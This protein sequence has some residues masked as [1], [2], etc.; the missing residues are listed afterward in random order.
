MKVH[1]LAL[2]KA[3]Q[4]R[5]VTLIKLLGTGK[6]PTLWVQL[7]REHKRLS[8]TSFMVGSDRGNKQ[9]IADVIVDKTWAN[10]TGAHQGNCGLFNPLA[11][12]VLAVLVELVSQKQGLPAGLTGSTC[13]ALSPKGKLAAFSTGTIG[14]LLADHNHTADIE[15]PELWLNTRHSYQ[16]GMYQEGMYQEG[17]YQEGMYQE[18]SRGCIKKVYSRL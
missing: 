2:V 17:M 5:G 18:G 6:S 13:Q 15:L 4:E 3:C 10:E 1:W 12:P 16:E 11:E 8:E 9:W 7:W 14:Y